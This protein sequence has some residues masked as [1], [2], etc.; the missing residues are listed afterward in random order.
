MWF[1]KCIRE[2]EKLNGTFSLPETEGTPMDLGLIDQPKVDTGRQRKEM[3]S[4]Q[5]KVVK[6]LDSKCIWNFMKEHMHKVERQTGKCMNIGSK[7]RMKRMILVLLKI[8]TRLDDW[9][10]CKIYIKKNFKADTDSNSSKTSDN[11][12]QV[13]LPVTN[14]TT[15]PDCQNKLAIQHEVQDQSLNASQFDHNGF[16]T[17]TNYRDV[18]SSSSNFWNQNYTDDYDTYLMQMSRDPSSSRFFSSPFP[19]Q[20]STDQICAELEPVDDKISEVDPSSMLPAHVRE[21]DENIS[22]NKNQNYTDDY[23]TYLMQMS[24]DP[25][26]SRLFSSPFPLQSSTDQICAGL[27]PV[28]DKISEVDPSSIVLPAHVRE[29]DNRACKAE[30]I[31]PAVRDEG[32][33]HVSK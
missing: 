8:P 12:D 25:S 11:S 33:D 3:R 31:Q 10:L 1:Q 26:S 30:P 17:L 9:V 24:R 15:S 2:L 21:C 16:S 23:D 27:K 18:E 32:D 13:V 20:S 19:L 29:Y 28:D 7:K 6:K 4:S 5:L 22:K 14:V